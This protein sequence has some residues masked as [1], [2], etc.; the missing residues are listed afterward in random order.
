MN[1]HIESVHEGK[2]PFRCNICEATFA[3]KGSL[4]THNV[5]IHE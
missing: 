4:K 1:R 3:Q 5:K 2:K